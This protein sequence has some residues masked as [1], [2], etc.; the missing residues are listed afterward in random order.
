[1]VCG[2][3]SA[4]G[5][6][7]AGGDVSAWAVERDRAQ[8]RLDLGEAAG[9]AGPEKMQRLLNFYAWDA[10][11][12]RDDVRQ[13]VVEAIGDEQQ[14]VL[15]LDETGFLKKGTGA[16]AGVGDIDGCLP[17]RQAGRMSLW[18]SR[19]PASSATMSSGWPATAKQACHCRR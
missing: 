10:D 11:G 7:A 2:A 18:A 17:L 8:E 1:M 19:I 12:V 3:V 6:T 16:G 5:V 13:A 14:G 4:G 9:D 15:V